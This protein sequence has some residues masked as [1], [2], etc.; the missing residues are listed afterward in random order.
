M[1]AGTTR[2]RLHQIF[3][4]DAPTT[5]QLGARGSGGRSG[6]SSLPASDGGGAASPLAQLNM[7]AWCSNPAERRVASF[8]VGRAA[9]VGRREDLEP[10]FHNR[11]TLRAS[12]AR[13]VSL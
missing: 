13:L 4:S 2:H 7:A 12:S 9:G 11:A 5:C 8:C 6:G 3:P 10:F 1:L